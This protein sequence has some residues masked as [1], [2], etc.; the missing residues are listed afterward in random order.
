MKKPHLSATALQTRQ[1]I[2]DSFWE[3][4]TK[5]RIEQ[6]TVSK[7]CNLAGYNRSTFYDYF[8][9]VYDV[10][11]QIENQIITPHRFQQIIL[12]NLLPSVSKKNIV[13]EL[14]QFY[15]ENSKYFPVLL[16]EHGD[17]A[18]R[19]KLLKRLAPVVY[20]TLNHTPTKNIQRLNYIM[21]YQSAAV[22]S[23]ITKWYSNGKDMP[24]EEF[25]DLLIA[26]TTNGVQKE[27]L[28]IT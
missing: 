27:I 10:L 22:L 9:D 14:L 13:I 23:M 17:P 28:R 7:I 5:N 12:S 1:N 3:F 15:E 21:E 11:D 2:L 4:Y 25:I 26:L 8:K 24:V 18:F 19:K 20:A 16:G 6:I